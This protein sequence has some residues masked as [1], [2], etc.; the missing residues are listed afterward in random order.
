MRPSAT[1]VLV[2]EALSYWC[3]SST[4]PAR[5]RASATRVLVSE[6]LSYWCMRP[7]ATSVFF[8]GVFFL[9]SVFFFV[10]CVLVVLVRLGPHEA[11]EVV[12]SDV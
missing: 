7:Y 2:Y 12:V 11:V 4:L 1:R 8:S 9:L 6:A 3:M 5:M 10:A